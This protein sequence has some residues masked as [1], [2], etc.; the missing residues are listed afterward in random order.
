MGTFVCL[1]SD[2]RR[3]VSTVG[4][5]SWG[6]TGWEAG[7]IGGGWVRDKV[8]GASPACQAPSL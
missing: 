4:S 1:T 6:W 7:W 5:C 8:K 3:G 2:L